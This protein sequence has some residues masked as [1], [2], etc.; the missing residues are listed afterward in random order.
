MITKLGGI[1]MIPILIRSKMI[2]IIKCESTINKII[3]YKTEKNSNIIQFSINLFDGF[4][5]SNSLSVK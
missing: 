3:F 5:F 2:S 1:N 4:A